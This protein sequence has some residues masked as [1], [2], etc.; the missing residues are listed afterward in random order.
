MKIEG[1]TNRQKSNRIIKIF[2]KAASNLGLINVSAVVADELAAHQSQENLTAITSG[3]SMAQ[4]RA[5]HLYAS[6]PPAHEAH[7]SVEYIKPLESD[8]DWKFFNFSLPP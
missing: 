2:S 8:P 7:W 4:G 5:L 3:L 6:N 1:I